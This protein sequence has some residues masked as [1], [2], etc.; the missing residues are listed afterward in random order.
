V[1]GG[2]DEGHGGVTIVN[3]RELLTGAAVTAATV[4]IEAQAAVVALA[5]GVSPVSEVWPVQRIWYRVSRVYDDGRWL[6]IDPP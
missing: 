5:G 2:A 6:F 1:A 4:L 3:R